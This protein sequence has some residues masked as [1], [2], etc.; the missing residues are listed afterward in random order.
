MIDGSDTAAWIV[1]WLATYAIH[2]TV[3]FAVAWLIDWRFSQRPAVVAAAWKFAVIGALLSAS[4]QVGLG[5]EPLGGRVDV[6]A[7]QAP[8]AA[9][10]PAAPPALG[11]D[12]GAVAATYD[13]MPTGDAVLQRAPLQRDDDELAATATVA[14]PTPPRA[15]APPPL[16]TTP[17]PRVVAGRWAWIAALGLLALVRSIA[18]LR[19]RVRTRAPAHAQA[20]AELAALLPTDRRARVQ[21]STCNRIAVP[22][23]AFVLRPEIIVPPRALSLDEP[24]RRTMLAHELAHVLHRDPAWRLLLA[25]LERVLFMQPLL[26]LARRRIEQSAEYLADGWAAQQTHA[27]IALARCLTEIASW[28]APRRGLALAATLPQPRSIL[29]R[30]VVRLIEG[31]TDTQFGWRGWALGALACSGM[32]LLAP[33]VSAAPAAARRDRSHPRTDIAQVVHADDRGRD[34]QDRHGPASAPALVVATDADGTVRVIHAPEPPQTREADSRKQRRRTAREVRRALA[35]ARREQRPIA[36]DELAAALAATAE[37][38]MV[39]F[40]DGEDAVAIELEADRVDVRAQL[41]RARRDLAQARAHARR[42]RAIM[43]EDASGVR[44]ELEA[45]T[46]PEPPEPAQWPTPPRAADRPD[47]PLPPDAPAPP[48]P[49]RRESFRV[50]PAPGFAP[51]PPPATLAPEPP[52]FAPPPPP[53][54]GFAPE[55]PTFFPE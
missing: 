8:A 49:P 10:I 53:P 45:P 18:A 41:D 5:L 15:D 40:T 55:A 26:R 6:V 48:A 44:L 3:L 47:A 29:G 25:V 11:G 1:A 37:P 43:I 14:P 32:V 7:Q 30:R 20:Q 36:L 23:A 35:R 51:E 54:P 22:M 46:P 19:R 39:V 42:L 31:G 38:R 9:P 4:V 2:S 13:A 33:M 21:L 16:A 27:P 12:R 34:A 28:V 50:V 17:W 52:S 24:A